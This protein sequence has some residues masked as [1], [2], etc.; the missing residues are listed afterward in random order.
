M[1]KAHENMLHI[2]SL[3]RNAKQNQETGWGRSLVLEHC[4]QLCS[5]GEG[6]EKNP[7]TVR[8]HFTPI[9]MLAIKK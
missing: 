2:T 9:M 5:V 1:V 7:K 3:W 6:R 4:A 8:Y